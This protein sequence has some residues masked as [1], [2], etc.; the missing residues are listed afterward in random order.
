MGFRLRK[1]PLPQNRGHGD[2]GHGARTLYAWT[3][4][5]NLGSDRAVALS[6]L[7]VK[8]RERNVE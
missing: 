3:T 6:I 4:Q 7:Y 5:N 1:P 8:P 2:G